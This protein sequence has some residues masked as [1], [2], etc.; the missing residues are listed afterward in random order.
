[1][2]VLTV[3]MVNVNQASELSNLGVLLFILFS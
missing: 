2:S 3:L 1:M